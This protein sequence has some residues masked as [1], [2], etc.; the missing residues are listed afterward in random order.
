[1]IFVSIV[2]VFVL[3]SITP[4]TER[5]IS[6]EN[7][8]AQ[9]NSDNNTELGGDSDLGGDTGMTESDLGGE[10]LGITVSDLENDTKVHDNNQ[11][12]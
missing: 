1:M 4:L 5:I 3:I 11:T 2:I 8:L 12:D 6:F 10:D 7:L 9:Q